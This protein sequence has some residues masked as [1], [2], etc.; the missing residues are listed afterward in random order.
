MRGKRAN[1]GCPRD[2]RGRFSEPAQRNSRVRE[3]SRV[4]SFPRWKKWPQPLVRPAN[5]RCG[6]T[7][8]RIHRS[9]PASQQI[10]MEFRTPALAT[11]AGEARVSPRGQ[12]GLSRYVD[13]DHPRNMNYVGQ[14]A[15]CRE[16][17]L[18][19]CLSRGRYVSYDADGNYLGVSGPDIDQILV[20]DRP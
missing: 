10:A 12:Y 14:F 7:G 20:S 5:C 18:A 3:L 16:D 2:R 6:P 11:D 19:Q 1:F 13:F 9:G 4:A 8:S 17:R 15:W